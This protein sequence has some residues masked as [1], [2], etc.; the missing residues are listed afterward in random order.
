MSLNL[1]ERPHV[2]PHLATSLEGLL[3][4]LLVASYGSG[5]SSMCH[6]SSTYDLN[7]HFNPSC[8]KLMLKDFCIFLVNYMQEVLVHIASKL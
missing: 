7:C 4:S 5:Y 3:H 8:H 6:L 1:I 2:C